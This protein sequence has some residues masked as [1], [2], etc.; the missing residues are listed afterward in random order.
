MKRGSVVSSDTDYFDG[1][2][3]LVPSC[4]AVLDNSKT[5]A[6]G[7]GGAESLSESLDSSQASR[8][9][10]K[11]KEAWATF[12]YEIV[13]ITHTLRLK[14]WRRVPLD[15]SNEIEVTRLSGALTNA[16]YVVSP[17]KNIRPGSGKHSSLPAPKN[18]PP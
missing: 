17:P 13:R 8:S 6:Y 15:E 2:E 11:E 14:G 16:V 7:G 12:K 4:E 1:A 3:D 10:K 18:P 9:S 5:M